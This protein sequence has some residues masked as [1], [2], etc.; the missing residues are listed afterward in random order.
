M[1]SALRSMLAAS[2]VAQAATSKPVPRDELARRLAKNEAVL[3]AAYRDVAETVEAGGAITLAAEWLID[4]F[5]CRR[6]ADLRH[7][8]ASATRLLPAT[9][10]ARS[11]PF[12]DL[13]RC[14][15]WFGLLSPTPTA[16]STPEVLRRYVRAYQEVQPLTIG[17]LW[18]VAITLR[19]VLV[20]NLR[21]LAERVV[22]S[23]DARRDADSIAD[24]LLGVGGRTVEPAQAALAGFERAELPNAFFVQLVLRLRDQDPSIASALSW[25]D[26]RLAT[27]GTTADAVVRDEHHRQVAVASRSAISLPVCA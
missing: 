20:E 22:A 25:L 15:E 4:T 27:Q 23:R 21:R 17:E 19:V 5:H 7:P 16:C 10:Q 26:G 12:V 24:R 2:P 9:A 14:S 1:S 11:R 3:L 8:P 18:A 13:P 6:R